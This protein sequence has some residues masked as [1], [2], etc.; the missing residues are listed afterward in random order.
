MTTLVSAMKQAEN[1]IVKHTKNPESKNLPNV[2]S[3]FNLA[4]GNELDD[5]TTAFAKT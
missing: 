4:A 3:Q 5:V 1:D 2:S